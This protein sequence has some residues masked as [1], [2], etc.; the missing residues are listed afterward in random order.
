MSSIEFF[1]KNTKYVWN[2]IK[3]A[4]IIEARLGL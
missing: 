2:E 4:V 1:Y 3:N